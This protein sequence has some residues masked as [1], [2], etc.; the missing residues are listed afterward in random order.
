[1][2]DVKRKVLARLLGSPSTIIP[3]SFGAAALAASAMIGNRAGMLVGGASILAGVG[4]M[5]TRWILSLDQITEEA[6]RRLLKREEDK[7]RDAMKQ[8]EASLV[9]D[10]DPRTETC[11]RQLCDHYDVFQEKAADGKLTAAGYQVTRQVEQLF[12]A[13]INQLGRSHELWEQAHGCRNAERQGV[14]DEREEI[15]SEVAATT[16][17]VV[18]A[19]EHFRQ[20]N[21]QHD[22]TDLHHLR[23]EL[24]ESL[25]VA[26]LVE[27][28]M[29]AW[30]NPLGQYSAKDF[31]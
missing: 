26:R 31:E 14:L 24:D 13:C 20:M 1:V 29:A 30:E 3:L 2:D 16:E 18:R 27:E 17:Q 10:G 22:E 8:L 21:E 9:L 19:V 4:V 12:Q 6:R 7:H 28:R 5:A 11:L 25:R 23:E 15:V